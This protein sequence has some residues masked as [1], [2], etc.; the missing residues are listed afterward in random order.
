VFVVVLGNFIVLKLFWVDLGACARLV[1]DVLGSFGCC[2]YMHLEGV[3]FDEGCVM[4]E[5]S[6]CSFLYGER[7]W[8]RDTQIKVTLWRSE[9]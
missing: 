1:L 6:V 4:E 8:R 5:G 3:I 2:V 7:R 9:I